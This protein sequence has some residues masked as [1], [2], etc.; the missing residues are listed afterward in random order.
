[1]E[2]TNLSFLRRVFLRA[3]S[4][5]P[6]VFGDFLQLVMSAGKMTSGVAAITEEHRWAIWILQDEA[7]AAE[8]ELL[9]TIAELV[10]GPELLVVALLGDT[11]DGAFFQ[12]GRNDQSLVGL[13]ID[14]D[15]VPPLTSELVSTH[16]WRLVIECCVEQ[17]VLAH[18]SRVVRLWL[19]FLL[20]FH[21]S[22]RLR[23]SNVELC[24]CSSCG[25]GGGSGSA[26]T[27]KRLWHRGLRLGRRSLRP[28]AAASALKQLH[29]GCIVSGRDDEGGSLLKTR[30]GPKASVALLVALC[31]ILPVTTKLARDHVSGLIVVG[32]VVCAV[33]ASLAGLNCGKG[34]CRLEYLNALLR[35]LLLLRLLESNGVL[36]QGQ[37]LHGV[38][39]LRDE[40]KSPL[41][42]SI[43]W[44]YHTVPRFVGDGNIPPVASKLI[45]HF[46]AGLVVD[47][48]VSNVGRRKGEGEIRV[49]TMAACCLL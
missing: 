20:E 36:G 43:L 3:L 38:D 44:L 39:I 22:F 8:I 49:R 40:E 17:H 5:E 19:L 24:I 45:G 48:A 4:A 37:Q 41:F 2:K 31:K 7:F 27:I 15:Q 35:L 25:R 13:L 1:M 28:A 32:R 26:V 34:D 11:K 12:F 6:L 42:K 23:S 30:L 47:G 18:I 21:S 46:Q 14:I 10:Q 16:S 9:V 29:P 33:D